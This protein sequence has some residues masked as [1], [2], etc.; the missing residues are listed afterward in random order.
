MVRAVEKLV[1]PL[2]R[3]VRLMV[4][5]GILR[6]VDDATKLQL[7]QVALLADE[8]RGNVERF[9]EYGFTSH[10]HSGAEAMVVSV[11]GS[12]DHCV[13]IAIDDRRYRLANLAAGEV[14]LYDDLGQSVVLKRTGVEVTSP[15]RITATAPQVDIVASTKVTVST[16][17]LEVTGNITAGGNITAAGNVADTAGAKTMAGM[18]TTYNTHIHGTSPEPNQQM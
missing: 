11:G 13:V 12:R 15:T 5:R 10:P 9:Q 17:L 4:S 8:V 6:L 18:R 1:A 3:R 7:V 2:S 14:A 16:P